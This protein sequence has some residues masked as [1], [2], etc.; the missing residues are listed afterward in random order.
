MK[1]A[2]QRALQALL[3]VGLLLTA[4]LALAHPGHGEHTHGGFLSGLLHPLMGLD[5]LLAMAAIGV[6]SVRQGPLMRRGAPLFMIGGMLLGAMLALGGVA[7]PGVEAGIIASV[8]LAG[9]LIATLTRLPGAAGAALV[10]LFMLFHGHAHGTEMP[11]GA[12][13]VSYMVGFLLATLAITVA[14]RGLGAWMQRADSR[15]LRLLGGAVAALGGAL[16]LS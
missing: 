13:L 3:A 14:G 16:A 1:T 4:T 7:L 10:A 8:L 5:H 9:I 12:A 6:W 2:P 15:W 11:H